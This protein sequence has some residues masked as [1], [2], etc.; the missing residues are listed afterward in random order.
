M[1]G[2]TL[3]AS[4]SGR[5]RPSTL[6]CSLHGAQ[7]DALLAGVTGVAEPIQAAERRPDRTT[8]ASPHGREYETSKAV[9]RHR[10]KPVRSL[11]A[12]AC[13]G[14][15]L[16]KPRPSFVPVAF[17]LN[18]RPRPTGR[19]FASPR[20]GAA[21]DDSTVFRLRWTSFGPARDLRRVSSTALRREFDWRR[22]RST[23][24]TVA[25][26]WNATGLWHPDRASTRGTAEQATVKHVKDEIGTPGANQERRVNDRTTRER[27]ERRRNPRGTPPERPRACWRSEMVTR[28]DESDARSPERR[29]RGAF[30]PILDQFWTVWTADGCRFGPSVD[31]PPSH[32]HEPSP[33]RE[34]SPKLV[35]EHEQRTLEARTLRWIARLP[36]LREADFPVVTGAHEADTRRALHTLRRLGW[37]E[38]VRVHSPEFDDHT[39]Y[40]LRVEAVP[41]FAAVF[42]LEEAEVRRN[43]PVGWSENLAHVTHVEITDLVNGLIV[44][45]VEHYRDTDVA[46]VDVR[47][48]PHARRDATSW[49]PP[50]VEAY[51]CLRFGEQ[52]AHFFVAWDR[53][54]APGAHR[55]A[56]VR[57]W[58]DSAEARNHWGEGRLPTILL[59][60]PS[61]EQEAEWDGAVS[62]TAERRDSVELDVL[63]SEE[64]DAGD[65]SGKTWHTLGGSGAT[66]LIANLEWGRAPLPFRLP[67]TVRFDLLA[68]GVAVQAPTVQEW[69]ARVLERDAAGP[70]DR[71]AAVAVLLAAPHR[72]ARELLARHPFLS[73]DELAERLGL[74]PVLAQRVLGDL[75]RFGLIGG[76]EEPAP[77]S[78]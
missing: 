65:V 5:Q 17:L 33:R 9:G 56:R 69:A 1:Q 72:E 22:A 2:G 75:T 55:R 18:L 20:E 58:Y 57:A 46:L 70:R 54:A 27:Q 44:A 73:L 48:L 21:S 74:T 39:R 31:R 23:N 16:H 35:K 25:C 64:G 47:A 4:T 42:Q 37:I 77:A 61:R 41:Q 40:L 15:N 24:S 6:R 63:V 30:G 28:R 29:V 67:Q 45:V 50:N 66:T 11:R 3:G 71:A 26:D 59:V 49:S 13:A 10:T 38:R 78:R 62:A 51:G 34:R 7:V 8:A 76:V 60:V 32:W 14:S 36:L 19:F 43:W 12:Y 68:R 53:V 52:F